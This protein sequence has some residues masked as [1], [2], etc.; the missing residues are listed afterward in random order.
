MKFINNEQGFYFPTNLD[1]FVEVVKRFFNENF[2]LDMEIC[3]AIY[4][5]MTQNW[6]SSCLNLL[7]AMI[8]QVNLKYFLIYPFLFH[9]MKSMV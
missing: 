2:I 1:K 5:Q 8:T 3:F 7:C 6:Q 9:A 4:F